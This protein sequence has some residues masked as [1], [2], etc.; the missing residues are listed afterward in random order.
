MSSTSAF[1]AGLRLHAHKSEAMAR[2][3]EVAPPPS[4]AI[5]SLDQGSGRA[6]L[7]CVAAGQRVCVGTAI[8]TDPETRSRVLHAPIAG[9]IR[10][11]EPRVVGTGTGHGLCVVI[12]NDGTGERD[13]A[14]APIDDAEHMAP[15]QWIGRLA[16]SGIVGLGGAAFSTAVKLAAALAQEATHLVLN[17]A[18]CE[19]WICC[20]DALMRSR[21]VRI[22]LGAQ[23]LLRA[24]GAGRCTI[25]VEDDKPEAIA[26]LQAALAGQT[27]ERIA[28][29]AV[30][31]VYPAGAE[32]QLLATITGIEVPSGSVPS[33]SGLLC[34][35]VG[36]AAAVAD[37]ALTGEPCIRRIVTITGGAIRRPGNLDALIGTPIADLVEHCG[38]YRGTPER[39]IAGGTMT[40][41]A[42]ADD[43][44]GLTK[45]VNCLVAASRHDLSPRGAEMP[46]IRCGDCANVC[47]VGLL[48]QQLDRWAAAGNF[49]RL[50]ALGL[51]DCIEC[52][53][54]DYVCPSQIALT[55]HFRAA[56]SAL[57]K[58]EDGLRR[59]GDARRRFERHQ[60]R[61]QAEA[62]AERR[63]FDEARRRARGGGAD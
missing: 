40:G 10:A 35:N 32:R 36:T 34:Q 5:V 25:A 63:A 30:P 48:P 15:Q 12:D 46:C 53:C 56:K 61:M 19:P 21:A 60:A 62:E 27:D 13:P 17:G 57:E 23:L 3:L 39:L 26:A 59:A 28:V 20:D 24:S 38:G 14:I 45:A 37:F 52:G 22:L 41:R 44:I 33:Q 16:D 54:C 50:D 1:P 4:Q 42:L 7:P 49:D 2:A 43:R 8:G 9:V 47:P 6:A 29:Q 58:R 11:V 55:Q 31:A 51:G 18:E